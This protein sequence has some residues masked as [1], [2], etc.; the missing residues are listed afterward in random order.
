M[1]NDELLVK[2]RAAR[3][4]LG[5]LVLHI[6]PAR[7][8]VKALEKLLDRQ[9]ELVGHINRL[10]LSALVAA[11]AGIIDQAA[12]ID[13]ATKK[14][15]ALTAKAHNVAKAIEIADKVIAVAAAIAT[16]L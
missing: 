3:K 11:S 16:K 8:E 5:R 12:A 9:N 7:D 2:L 15:T 10:N 6:K 14:L 13:A 4:Q 1:T